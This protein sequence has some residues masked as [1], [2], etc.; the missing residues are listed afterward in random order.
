MFTI[1]RILSTKR[2]R[3]K[4]LKNVENLK[5]QGK[6][7]KLREISWKIIVLRENSRESS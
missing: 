3:E 7:G 1:H 6:P 4:S 2:K 5:D